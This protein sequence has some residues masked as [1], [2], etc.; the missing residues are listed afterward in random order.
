MRL[1]FK[2]SWSRTF[3]RFVQ[4][5]DRWAKVP[6]LPIRWHHPTGP[7]FG[8]M[9]ALLV[10]DGREARLV[11]ERAIEAEQPSA[12]TDAAAEAKLVITKELSLTEAPR[13]A[14]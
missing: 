1:V 9:L 7:H 8:N 6:P 10:L 5:F 13:A 12:R 11:L 3:E 14:A 2:A 4:L